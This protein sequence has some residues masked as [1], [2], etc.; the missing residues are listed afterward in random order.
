M[1]IDRSA[2]EFLFDT[3]FLVVLIS[4][5]MKDGLDPCWP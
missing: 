4:Y 1:I 5:A 2:N 3:V